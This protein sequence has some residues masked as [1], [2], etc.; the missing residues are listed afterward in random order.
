MA[1]TPRPVKSKEFRDAIAEGK[2]RVRLRR[3]TG[4]IKEWV[5]TTDNTLIAEADRWTK[6]DFLKGLA[7]GQIRLYVLENNA[8]GVDGA[9]WRDFRYT[10]IIEYERI[11]D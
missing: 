9:K 1:Y 4:D 8:S 6:A 5:V 2:W 11:E 3:K 10:N 7:P